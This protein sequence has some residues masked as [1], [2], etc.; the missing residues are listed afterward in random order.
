VKELGASRGVGVSGDYTEP[1]QENWPR[2]N[3]LRAYLLESRKM[4][5]HCPHCQSTDLRKVSLVYQE[6]RFR[7]ESANPSAR[8]LAGNGWAGSGRRWGQLNRRPTKPTLKESSS[9]R[10]MVFPEACG[11]VRTQLLC[12]A[13]S[14]RP[15]GHEYFCHGLI[16]ARI[17]LCCSCFVPVAVPWVSVLETQ[18]SRLSAAIR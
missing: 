1:G 2:M 18:S 3:V 8:V 9:T 15:L 7:C 11:L 5:M 14:L 10:E 6:G 17:H 4:E 12:G 13:D 16:I